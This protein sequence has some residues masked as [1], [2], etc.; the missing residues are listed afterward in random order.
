MGKV[1]GQVWHIGI[2]YYISL[3]FGQILSAALA[4]K[5]V[6]GGFTWTQSWMIGLGMLGRAELFFVV[7]NECK[8][9]SAITEQQFFALTIAAILSTSRFL[10]LLH[11]SSR[12]T[13]EN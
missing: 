1:I 7:L 13:R 2:I 11:C 10:L 9:R 6:P 12:F 4:A 8:K 3:F 5:F